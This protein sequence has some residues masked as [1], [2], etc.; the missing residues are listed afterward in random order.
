MQIGGPRVAEGKDL[1]AVDE[2]LHLQV[3]H[4]E[5]NRLVL[6]HVAVKMADNRRLGE[7]LDS[8]K[9]FEKAA[10]DAVRL[11]RP[12]KADVL[13][14]LRCAGSGL[15]HG[16]PAQRKGGYCHGGDQQREH[17]LVAHGV[18]PGWNGTSA[19]APCG[20]GARSGAFGHS[21]GLSENR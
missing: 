18:S 12:Q 6:F 19:L 16:D 8:R 2:Q 17:A 21:E 9:A 14:I 15:V 20:K 7:P 13:I 11:D 1:P 5:I 10:R 4:P 3:R